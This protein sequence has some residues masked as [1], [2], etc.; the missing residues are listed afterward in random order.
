MKPDNQRCRSREGDCLITPDNKKC[1]SCRYKKCLQ[2]GM[3]PSLVQ[4]QKRK[5][6]KTEDE[7]EDDEPNVND[8]LSSE[9]E[10][11]HSDAAPENLITSG[12]PRQANII[13]SNQIENEFKR[14]K[15]SNNR[16][17]STYPNSAIAG[18]STSYSPWCPQIKQ[19]EESPSQQF[20]FGSVSG[21]DSHHPSG[22][23]RPSLTGYSRP[24]VI[25]RAGREDPGRLQLQAD[26]LKFH[27]NIL[28]HTGNLFNY[29]A[30]LLN[31]Q[32]NQKREDTSV[33]KQEFSQD[34][35]IIKKE[36]V[37]TKKEEE[38]EKSDYLTQNYLN[39]FTDK[40][41]EEAQELLAHSPWIVDFDNL[42]D[43]SFEPEKTI[44]SEDD[45]KA[46]II[47]W[48]KTTSTN[49]ISTNTSSTSF[50]SNQNQKSDSKAF[51]TSVICKKK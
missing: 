48:L 11:I 50:P 35:Q 10:R 6:I 1:I 7:D 13:D 38:P 9:S 51:Q 4:G 8:E 18:P 32:N 3:D 30:E 49:P 5:S 36:E 17:T 44:K 23:P 20:P 2:I 21:C 31:H 41:F 34:S 45:E 40:V 39:N 28:T 29:H 27:G 22:F 43:S 37:L 47:N 16:V 25:M 33:I 24:S 14:Q 42:S 15:Y 19:E 12:S 26:L 46:A